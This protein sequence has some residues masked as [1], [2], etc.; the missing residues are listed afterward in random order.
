MIIFLE[1]KVHQVSHFESLQFPQK[2]CNFVPMEGG[3]METT[4]Q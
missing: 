1:N 3:G 2:V 4:G